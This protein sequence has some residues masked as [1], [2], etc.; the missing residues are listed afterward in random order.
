M[1]SWTSLQHPARRDSH[2]EESTRRDSN[3]KQ[4]LSFHPIFSGG[5][6]INAF[7]VDRSAHY[8]AVGGTSLHLWDL[9]V[10]KEREK[11]EKQYVHVPNSRATSAAYSVLRW[12][13]HHSTLA[14]S[15]GTVVS[16]W[17]L[18]DRTGNLNPHLTIKGAHKRA[19]TDLA[20]SPFKQHTLASRS[21]D[22]EI[23]IWDV[24]TKTLKVH[25]LQGQ[26]GPGFIKW[27]RLNSSLVAST[28][29]RE[30]RI[31][32][33]RLN[34]RP[35]IWDIYEPRTEKEKIRTGMPVACAQFTPFGE[36]VLTVGRGERCMQL[37]SL[38]D[39]LTPIYSFQGHSETIESFEWSVK[40]STKTNSQTYGLVSLAKDFTLN[41]WSV[42]KSLQLVE[43]VDA[44]LGPTH[45]NKNLCKFPSTSRSQAEQSKTRS[46][47]Q[48]GRRAASDGE[49]EDEETKKNLKRRASYSH[50]DSASSSLGE[51]ESV[52]QYGGKLDLKHELSMISQKMS[53][54]EDVTIESANPI[55]RRALRPAGDWSPIDVPIHSAALATNAKQDRESSAASIESGMAEDMIKQEEAKAE[56]KVLI[57]M[58]IAFPSFYPHAQPSFTYLPGTTIDQERQILL[59]RTLAH[60]A[61]FYSMRGHPCLQKLVMKLVNLQRSLDAEVK[62]EQLQKQIVMDQ[63]KEVHETVSEGQQSP[64]GTTEVP[65]P[66]DVAIAAESATREEVVAGIE[67]E[68]AAAP[69]AHMAG[70]TQARRQRSP[71]LTIWNKFWAIVG[72]DDQETEADP[73][74]T[75]TDGPAATGQVEQR[76]QRP[77]ESHPSPLPKAHENEDKENVEETHKPMWIPGKTKNALFG[78]VQTSEPGHWRA[79]VDDHARQSLEMLIGSLDVEMSHTSNLLS[80]SDFQKF[81]DWELLYSTMEHGISLHTPTVIIIEDSKKYVFGAFVTGTW[82]ALGKYSGTGESFLFTLSPY[83][84]VFPWTRANSLF[85]C[86]APHSMSIGG[87]S[88]VGLWLDED[89]EFG[90]SC[91]CETYGNECL[92]SG[93]D[94]D[95]VVLEAWGL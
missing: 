35:Q 77:D 50:V 5:K 36:G 26:P 46:E 49:D 53:D 92:A 4:G 67:K 68:A 1:D 48:E 14:S 33:L 83:F 16:V 12:N 89:F 87:G 51:T 79:K 65:R 80:Q 21:A 32:D 94:F 61:T 3:T 75:D 17:K 10:A 38:Y 37:W 62:L 90:S 45:G 27:N 84:K 58:Q 9:D 55:N 6:Q 2:R 34:G 71:S 8:V 54:V 15:V 19:I 88:H 70:S 24:R 93:R 81:R 56:R 41:V 23:P 22:A 39:H 95:C 76:Q 28:H 60:I 91:P 29:N 74:K 66:P 78:N 59:K 73:T 18:D 30:V 40:E 82:D 31:W 85:M 43:V 42:P 44:L 64:E 25:C 52:N 13:P 7:A 57:R 63:Q 69:A 72:P 20:W 86:G 11:E 47:E